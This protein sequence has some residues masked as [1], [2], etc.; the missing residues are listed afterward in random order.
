MRRW[1]ALVVVSVI[2]L[3]Q[4]TKQWIVSTLEVGESIRVTGFFQISH[5]RNTGAAFGILK[6]ATSFLVLAAIAGVVVFAVIIAKRP[7]RLVGLAAALVAAGALGNLIDRAFRPAFFRG[8]VVDFLDF[9]VW[10]AFNVADMAVTIGAALL[11]IA[12]FSS[13]DTEGDDTHPNNDS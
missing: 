12:S 3:D 7:P 5:I 6:G 8:S 13:G 11:F 2:A 10:P 9:R 1:F 4:L